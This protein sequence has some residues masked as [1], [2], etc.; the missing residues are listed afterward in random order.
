MASPIG[1][2]PVE[3]HDVPLDEAAAKADPLEQFKLWYAQ[4]TAQVTHPDAVILA[5]ANT[6]GIPS[7]RSVLLKGADHKGFL[8]FTNEL[9]RK[10]QELASNP[11][12]ALVF[13]WHDLS[14]EVRIEGSIE[15]LSL[16]DSAMSYFFSRPLDSQL[17]SVA[18]EQSQVIPSRQGLLSKIEDLRSLWKSKAPSAPLHW[19]AYRVVPSVYEFWQGRPSRLNDRLRYR[20]DAAGWLIERL[21]P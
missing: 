17:V 13:P 1:S 12:A 11:H 8:F 7:A 6:A 21:A 20:Q 5:T 10:G 15:K 4:A 19:R 2:K 16:S 9:S 14:R 18:S 3:Y